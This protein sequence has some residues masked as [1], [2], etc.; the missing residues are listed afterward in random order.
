MR[1]KLGGRRILTPKL[2]Q[3]GSVSLLSGGPCWEDDR[4]SS[5]LRLVSRPA[6]FRRRALLGRIGLDCLCTAI[7]KQCGP[8]R[9][10][11]SATGTRT[12]ASQ[13]TDARVL[14]PDRRGL[15]SRNRDCS[16]GPDCRLR[17]QIVRQQCDIGPVIRASPTSNVF[18]RGN[19]NLGQH[20][21]QPSIRDGAEHCHDPDAQ[22]RRRIGTSPHL[23]AG[24]ISLH[25]R[26]EPGR[27]RRGHLSN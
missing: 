27:D 16:R 14:R 9:H 26:A 4:K 2:G 21:R 12:G 13:E 3:S 1:R 10:A 7:R 6:I 18:R 11:G 23:R 22:Q 20:H 8:G 19:S 25:S 24:R 15:S 5:L 17:E